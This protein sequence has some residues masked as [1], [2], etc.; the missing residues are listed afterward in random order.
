MNGQKYVW[1]RI[2][3]GDKKPSNAIHAGETS[4]DG[5]VFVGRVN[6]TPGKVNLDSDNKIW[7]FWVSGIPGSK[8]LGEMLLTN[9]KCD[10]VKIKRGETFPDNAIYSGTDIKG[11]K[12]W[13][14]KRMDNGE[15]GKITCA[16]NSAEPPTMWNL[17]T[18]SGGSSS[19]C[20]VLTIAGKTKETEDDDS[21][22]WTVED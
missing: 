21:G 19:E 9:E 17:W 16:D 13:V 15:P 3:R 20:Y 5:H 14:G 2:K 11:D 4:T 7:D 12:V 8:Q 18:H 1:K 6:Y 22:S 10:W